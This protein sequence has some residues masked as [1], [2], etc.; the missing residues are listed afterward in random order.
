MVVLNFKSEI[1]QGQFKWLSTYLSP[2][3]NPQWDISR[4]YHDLFGKSLVTWK[5][6]YVPQVLPLINTA[7]AH[8]YRKEFTAVQR[9]MSLQ[10][11]FAGF[12]ELG[13]WEG[14][15]D[16]P[17]FKSQ[18]MAVWFYY[19]KTL[20]NCWFLSDFMPFAFFLCWLCFVSFH[21]N[22]S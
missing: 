8:L 9:W 22:K 6:L 1:S 5:I 16:I 10:W 18:L 21:C 2:W 19:E 3:N 7:S 12:W 4:V 15:Y 20:G 13:F 11:L 17:H 14:S